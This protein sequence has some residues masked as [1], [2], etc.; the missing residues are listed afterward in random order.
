MLM[1]SSTVRINERIPSHIVDTAQLCNYARAINIQFT[2]FA[3]S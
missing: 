3:R 2:S 1:V